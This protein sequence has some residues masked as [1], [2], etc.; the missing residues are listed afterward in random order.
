MTLLL[1]ATLLGRCLTKGSLALLG[2][3]GI[4]LDTPGFLLLFFL[5]TLSL[6]RNTDAVSG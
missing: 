5:L 2:L 6:E 3:L 1:L 4:N